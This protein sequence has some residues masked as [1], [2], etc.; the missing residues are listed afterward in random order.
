MQTVLRI[1]CGILASAALIAFFGGF[2]ASF[3]LSSDDQK[4]EEKRKE[5]PGFRLW[6]TRR[7]PVSKEDYPE[8]VRS[9]W[10]FRDRCLKTFAICCGLMALLAVTAAILDVPF[11]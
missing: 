5:P 7:P 9:L 2:F 8:E 1:I 4:L 10:V 3:W 11:T 6:P